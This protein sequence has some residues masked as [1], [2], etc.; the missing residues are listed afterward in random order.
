[1]IDSG[2]QCESNAPTPAGR[3]GGLRVAN[4]GADW[5]I[6]GEWLCFTNAEITQAC[7]LIE[8]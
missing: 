4:A 6:L 5:T 3:I 8:N 2:P 1:M 7:G